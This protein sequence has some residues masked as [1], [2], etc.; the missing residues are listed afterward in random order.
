MGSVGTLG[1]AIAALGRVRPDLVLL[2]LG[3]PDGNG[4]RLI[5]WLQRAG[6][7]ADVL[8]ISVMGDEA[9]VL[10][11]IEAGAAGYLLKDSTNDEVLAAIRQ[12]REGG[13][14]LSPSI[15]VH[16]MRRLKRP[17]SGFVAGETVLTPRE[18]ELLRLIAK[19][20]SYE[21]V[22]SILG[23]RHSSVATYAK[24]VYRKLQ[25]HGRAEAAFEAMQMGLVGGP[26]SG[27]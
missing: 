22:A 24:N 9:S 15:A 25:V 21:E 11:A 7:R 16:L 13:A 17:Q 27:G 26:G 18:T 3:L 20:L 6:A 2:D 23:L 1:E 5:H 12:V 10:A 14:P 8:V 4:V 19:G